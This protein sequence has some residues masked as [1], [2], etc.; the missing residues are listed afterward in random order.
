MDTATQGRVIIRPVTF[1][2]GRVR[3]R[4]TETSSFWCEPAEES[5]GARPFLV[6]KSDGEE[7][8]SVPACIDEAQRQFGA[9]SDQLTYRDAV[10]LVWPHPI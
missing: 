2:S 4:P 6:V 3:R 7:C 9:P 10:V 1:Q 5:P 8:P